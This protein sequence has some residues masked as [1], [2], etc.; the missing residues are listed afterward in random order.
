MGV[1]RRHRKSV[2]D[3]GNKVGSKEGRHDTRT[4]RDQQHTGVHR[5]KTRAA[6]RA[7]ATTTEGMTVSAKAR[8]NDFGG[9][10]LAKRTM[11]APQN[12]VYGR[13]NHAAR[14]A[15]TQPEQ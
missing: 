12:N 11:H 3:A 4:C 15:F 6:V 13:K 9:G 10:V 14:V 8:I 5:G 1:E 2:E 7:Y